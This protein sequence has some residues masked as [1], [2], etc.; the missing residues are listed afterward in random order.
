MKNITQGE[1]ISL[2]QAEIS[3]NNIFSGISWS[4][5]GNQGIEIDICAFLLDSSNKVGDDGDFVF[6]NQKEDGAKSILLNTDPGNGNDIQLFSIKLDKIPPRVKKI[7]FVAS[8]DKAAERSQNFGHVKDMC[9]RIFE[10]DAFDEKTIVFKPVQAER[11]TSIALGEL[12]LHQSGW[13]F[14]GLGNGFESGLDALALSYGINVS[15]DSSIPGKSEGSAG[16]NGSERFADQAAAENE[17]NIKKHLNR[18]LPKIKNAVDQNINESSTRMILDKLFMEILGYKMEEVKVE[19]KIQGRRADYVLAVND[20]DVLIVEAKK[21]GLPLKD[22]HIF[23]ACSYAAYSGIKF[24]LLTNLCEF[25]LFKVKTKDIVESEPIFSVD[26]LNDLEGGIKNLAMISRLGMTQSES[27]EILSEQV[28]ASS[29]S[30]ISRIL[31]NI[32][33]IDK[34]KE[35]IKKEQNCDVLQEQ[36]Q[37]T[38]ELLLSI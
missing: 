23:Q 5:A 16:S 8:I 10:P 3:G 27:L 24:V 36:I 12:Y 32:E 4:V 2:L 33:V 20:R 18:I 13:K 38:I 9:I 6:Y 37:G 31:L 19:V 21:A 22:G 1:N 28:I 14:R 34:I 30:N 17:I 15:S 26:L 7:V 25:I 29:P 35:I 11:E